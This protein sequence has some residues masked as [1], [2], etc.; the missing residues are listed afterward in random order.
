MSEDSACGGGRVVA[1]LD[2]G[3]FVASGFAV[4]ELVRRQFAR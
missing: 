3:G 4:N 2:W 1:W